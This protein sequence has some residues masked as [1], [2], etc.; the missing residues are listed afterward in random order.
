[1][2]IAATSSRSTVDAESARSA[3]GR[4]AEEVVAWFMVVVLGMLESII[5]FTLDRDKRA[6]QDPTR[7]SKS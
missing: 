6:V 4:D 7:Y 3:C 5:G 2:G 1:M